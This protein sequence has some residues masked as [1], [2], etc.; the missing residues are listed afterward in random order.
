MVNRQGADAG[1]CHHGPSHWT[2]GGSLVQ[3]IDKAGLLCYKHNVLAEARAALRM[4]VRMRGDEDDP[5][6]CRHRMVLMGWCSCVPC[7]RVYF[8]CADA[9]AGR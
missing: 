4:P 9:H 7:G 8:V 2:S 1:S 6:S 5:A 3:Q